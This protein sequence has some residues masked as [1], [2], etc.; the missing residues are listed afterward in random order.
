MDNAVNLHARDRS[1][2]QRRQQNAAQSVAE[3]RAKAALKRFD[4]KATISI[5]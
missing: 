1:P 5:A 3:R 4:H 2:L